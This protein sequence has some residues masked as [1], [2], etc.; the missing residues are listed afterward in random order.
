MVTAPQ[1]AADRRQVSE[2]SGCVSQ[3][4]GAIENRCHRDD[5]CDRRQV[6]PKT[7]SQKISATENNVTGD[8]CHRK[9]C[10]RRQVPQKTDV[11]KQIN[12]HYS[13]M[14]RWLI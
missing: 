14:L 9:Q 3:K 10:H 5:E 7:M 13:T 8:W 2:N 1:R 12:V 4:I 6:P 11:T